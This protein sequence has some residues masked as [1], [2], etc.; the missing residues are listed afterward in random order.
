MTVS[1]SPATQWVLPI[2]RWAYW[3]EDM[4]DPPEIN[5]QFMEAGLRRRL[6]PLLK[7]AL[8]LAHQCADAHTNL[9]L[10]FASRNGDISRTTDML[11]SLTLGDT[12]SPTAFSMSVLN[13]APGTYSIATADRSPNIAIAATGSSIGFGLLEAWMQFS[14]HPDQ[15]LLFVYADEP[16][17]AIYQANH[18][19]AAPHAIALLL[20]PDAQ[21]EIRCSMQANL[22]TMD[23]PFPQALA[24]IQC[25]INRTSAWQGEGRSWHWSHHDR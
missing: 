13:A 9:R 25:L 19:H 15:P 17:P 18:L 2:L 1:H 23:S 10:V 4:Q 11:M 6:S 16:P 20:G 8:S 3:H 24:F 5:L 21:H 14:N 12:P 22:E 7:Q